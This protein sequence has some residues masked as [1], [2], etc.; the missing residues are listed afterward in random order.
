MCP[1]AAPTS[2]TRSVARFGRA[3]RITKHLRRNRETN[4]PQPHVNILTRQF[5]PCRLEDH[6]YTTLQDD[7]M[8][9]TFKHGNPEVLKKQRDI[10]L[11]F[12]PDDPYVQNRYNPPVGGS[13][14]GRKPAPPL[15]PENVIRLEKISIHTMVKEAISTKS[16][17]LGA[18]MALRALTGETYKGGGRHTVEGIQIVRGKKSVGGWIRPG[19][20]V[21][22]KV[23][24]KGQS[25]YDFLGT[26]VE[27]VLPRL[28][29]F[30]GVTLPPLSS[31]TNSPSAVSGVVSFGLPPVAMGLFPQIEVNLDSYPRTYGMHIHFVTNAT[32]LGA[33]NRARALVSAFQ[34]PFLRR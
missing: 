28:R 29:D 21:G 10:R 26:L 4:L 13:Q 23:D 31:S 32:G 6:Y 9:M 14:M 18:I 24:L 15:T 11:K 34:I 8:Y 33:Q 20:P 16:N 19:I 5:A 1:L 3:P 17:L 22:V 27:F 12:D 7:L 2:A 25:M 30:N